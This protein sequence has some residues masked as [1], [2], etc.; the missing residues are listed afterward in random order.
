MAV[1]IGAGDL[2]YRYGYQRFDSQA[3]PSVIVTLVVMISLIQFG[4]D[5]LA[6]RLNKRG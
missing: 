2:A 3:M 1:A 6:K 4:R 5:K